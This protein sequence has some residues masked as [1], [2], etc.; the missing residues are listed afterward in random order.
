MAI[1]MNMTRIIFTLM[2]GAV[3]CVARVDGA[4]AGHGLGEALVFHAP[5]DGKGDAA[6]GKGDLKIYSATSM[7][8]PRT[9]TAGLPASRFVTLA[10]GEG[11]FG[12]GLQFHR[13]SSEMIFF[14]AEKNFPYQQK[15][16]SGTVSL[17][18]KVDPEME[19]AP[20]YTDP[21]QITPREW[22]DA[23]FFVEF[24]A[25]DKPRHFRLGAYADFKIWNPDNRD[26]NII[27]FAEK[28]L[29]R[30][31]RP[32]FNRQSWTHVVFTFEKFNTGRKDGIATLYLNGNAQGQLSPREQ[33]FTWDP[34]KTLIM[35]GLSY[36]GMLD[37]LAVFNRALT[38]KEV[39]QLHELKNGVA[40]LRP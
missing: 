29:V 23:A 28:P 10:A 1:K 18:L 26:W 25:D 12:D 17:W 15:D 35:V 2:F 5:F 33:T 27:P 31:E 36:V 6:F 16:W 32:P 4:Q 13:K 14:Q 39:Q 40:S 37:E 30:V 22:N 24:T 21:I 19:L 9:G 7:K 8:H 3:F 34:A 38:S 11:K 20:G